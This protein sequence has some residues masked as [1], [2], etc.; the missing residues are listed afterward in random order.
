M[1]SKGYMEAYFGL[2][3]AANEGTWT[4][5]NGESVNYIN[6]GGGEPN[7]YTYENYGMFY[8]WA[9]PNGEWNDGD[10]TGAKEF[11][12]EWDSGG[13]VSMILSVLQQNLPTQY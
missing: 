8:A 3:D 6:W 11:I 7:G 2:S 12:C 5:V 4:W 13:A 1:N 9:Y 10:F